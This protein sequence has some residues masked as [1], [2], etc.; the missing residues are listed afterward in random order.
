MTLRYSARALAVSADSVAERL[1]AQVLYQHGRHTS[2]AEVRSWERSVPVLAQ[3]LVDAALGNVEVI[4]E[5]QL[6]L[7][8]KRADAVLAGRH[9][10]T[11]RPSY[12]VVELK[13]WSSAH[14]WE[15][16]ESLVT[17]DGMP[18]G[19]R[20]HP[21]RQVRG[22]CEYVI[23]FVRSLSDQPDAV[24]GVAY[25]HN[26]TD[27]DRISDLYLAP[28]DQQ[29]Q[30]FTSAERAKLHAFLRSR[31][32]PSKSGADAA[33]ELLSSAVAP[34]RPLLAVAA[35]EVRE[36]EQFVLQDDQQRAVDI[37][38]HEVDRSRQADR[39]SVIM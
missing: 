26:V 2:P 39:K 11:G 27:R 16:D 28:L 18:G 1:L 30:L 38:K 6:P 8:S 13:Q 34:S 5:Y 20:L 31:L 24:A 22:Y 12:V 19:P 23:D 14:L 25:L 29:G 3:D 15:D 9:P 37:V 21:A 33:D 32:D 10:R 7:T 17:V 36:R 4:L 35:Q